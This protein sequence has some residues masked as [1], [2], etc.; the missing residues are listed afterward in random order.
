MSIS[1]IYE[2][3]AKGGIMMIPILLCSVAALAIFFERLWALQ[4]NR[5]VPRR[6]LEVVSDLVRKRRFEQAQAICEG[7]DSSVAAV[8]ASGLRHANKDRGIIKEVMEEAGRREAAALE[9]GL[10]ALGAIA[11]TAPL[12]GLLGTVLGMIRVFQQVVNQAGASA[13]GAVNAAALANGIW[14]ALVTTAAGLSVAIPAF[15]LHKY[16][17]GRVDRLLDEL[18]ERSLDLADA[19]VAEEFAPAPRIAT[20]DEPNQPHTPPAAAPAPQAESAPREEAR[21]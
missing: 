15:L 13:G 7:N 14:E 19:M 5:V 2:L 3:L 16:L 4:R 18:E 6:L 11:N 20:T 10:G 21:P 8:L 9:R 1:E 12:L 17:S